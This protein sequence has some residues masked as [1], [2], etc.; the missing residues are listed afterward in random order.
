MC[1]V[2]FFSPFWYFIYFQCIGAAFS[3]IYIFILFVYILI[4]F[5]LYY[6]LSTF[7]IY[8]LISFILLLRVFSTCLSVC[9]SFTVE[10]ENKKVGSELSRSLPFPDCVISPLHAVRP[11]CT[12]RH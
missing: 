11:V 3:S 12:P 9:I 2:L 5:I 6:F 7:L 1:D 10:I 8:L 4:S